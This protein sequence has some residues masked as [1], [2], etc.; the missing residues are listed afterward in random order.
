MANH[1]L[2]SDRADQPLDAS[3]AQS[4]E[5]ELDLG[6]LELFGARV[7][8]F[9]DYDDLMALTE[10]VALTAACGVLNGEVLEPRDEDPYPLSAFIDEFAGWTFSTIVP[11]VAKRRG[12]SVDPD[13]ISR[14]AQVEMDTVIEALRTTL[15]PT[16][17]MMEVLE[18]FQMAGI[19]PSVVS[20]SALPRLRVCLE[21]TRQN[22][23]I[24]HEHVYSAQSSLTPPQPKPRPDI[25][26]H[27]M[28][29]RRSSPED[30][31]AVEDSPSGVS[32]AHAAGMMVIGYV[33]S[34]EEGK[35]LDRAKVLFDRGASYVLKNMRELPH[36]L[37]AIQ[38]GDLAFLERYS[39][40]AW[41]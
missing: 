4:V 31:V 14:L 24:Q 9:L 22:E 5:T 23:F 12:F 2:P 28:R 41:E 11:E 19:V 18:V 26:Q 40:S 8:V 15:Q 1:S 6:A 38:K 27:A 16:D 21:A 3:S 35:R 37:V 17:G 13:E 33:G 25:Y 39:K 32:S 10:R 20:S 29:E 36:V 30:S 7:G 34:L